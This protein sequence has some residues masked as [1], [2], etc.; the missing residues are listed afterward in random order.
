VDEL[1]TSDNH[2][3]LKTQVD[4]LVTAMTAFSPPA[5]GQLTLPPAYQTRLE[6]VIAANWQAA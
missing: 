4:Q 3:L 2:L 5:S 1:R 6:P